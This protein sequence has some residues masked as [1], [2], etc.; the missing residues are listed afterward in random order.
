MLHMPAQPR[1]HSQIGTMNRKNTDDAKQR[2]EM[3]NIRNDLSD[4]Q[5]HIL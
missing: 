1:K 2:T 5:M 3:H 4:I